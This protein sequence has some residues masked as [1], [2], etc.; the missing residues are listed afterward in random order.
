MGVADVDVGEVGV[1]KKGAGVGE[2]GAG[3]EGMVEWRGDTVTG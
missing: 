1:R 3:G 2:V